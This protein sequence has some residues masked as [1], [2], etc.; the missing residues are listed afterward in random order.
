M[1]ICDTEEIYRYDNCRCNQQFIILV[2]LTCFQYWDGVQCK[3]TIFNVLDEE[4]IALSYKVL[5]HGK[6]EAI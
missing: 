5:L 2:F 4:N 6:N 3:Y 1:I